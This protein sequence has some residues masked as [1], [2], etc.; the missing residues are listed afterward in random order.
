M[1]IQGSSSTYSP[2][3]NHSGRDNL[4]KIFFELQYFGPDLRLT[5]TKSAIQIRS[6]KNADCRPGTKCR[7][8]TA[9]WVQNA[10]WE[11]IL[12]FR[13]IRGNMSSYN[14]PSV[15]QSLFR[16][17]L[18]RLSARFLITIVLNIISSLHIVFSLC[19][20]VGWCDVCTDFTN[21][22]KVDVDVNEMS[23]LN[24]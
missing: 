14:L 9:D 11:F 22:I 23:L 7:L 5:R 20:R 24:I 16:D 10:D 12:F 15:T 21:V 8:Q 1:L 18:S 19:A 6:V 2:Y 3:I 13:L 4:T 17:H